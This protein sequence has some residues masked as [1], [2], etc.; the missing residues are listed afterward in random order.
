MTPAPSPLPRAP[1]LKASPSTRSTATINTR[2]R[3]RSAA[4]AALEGR[5]GHAGSHRRHHQRPRNF[6]SMSDDDDDEP[7]STYMDEEILKRKLLWVLNEEEGLVI[8][9][10]TE[11]VKVSPSPYSSSVS[12]PRGR[13]ECTS[14]SCRTSSSTPSSSSKRSRRSTI[15]SFF[16]P[17]TNFID[18]KDDDLSSSWRSFVQLS[19]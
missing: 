12:P 17:L 4:L 9:P 5:G 15:E 16:S 14:G 2:L 7:Q 10:E 18:L 1:A 11:N 8:P 3:N 13:S 19:S 6:M